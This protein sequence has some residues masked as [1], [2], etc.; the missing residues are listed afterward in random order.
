MDFQMP[1]YFSIRTEPSYFKLDLFAANILIQLPGFNHIGD[2]P[3]I[4]SIKKTASLESLNT[5]LRE[6]QNGNIK[7]KR[8]EQKHKL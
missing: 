1:F 6:V 8:K 3:L 7:S 5:N 4:L 2:F